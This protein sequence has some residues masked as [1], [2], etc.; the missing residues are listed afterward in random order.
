YMPKF[1][2]P[3]P[4]KGTEGG[5]YAT[6][7]L[8]LVKRDDD[9]EVQ[10][11]LKN[12]NLEVVYEAVNAIQATPYRLNEGLL[13]VLSQVA[14]ARGPKEVLPFIEIPPMPPRLPEKTTPEEEWKK[15]QTER[16]RVGKLRRLATRNFILIDTRLSIAESLRNRVFYFPH[17]VDNRSRAYPVPGEVHP[18]AD[19]MSRALLEFA[20]GKPLGERGVFWLSVHLANLWGH[21]I[22]KLPLA[23]RAQWVRDHEKEIVDSATR[24]LDGSMFWAGAEKKWRFLAASFEWAGYVQK[25][26]DFVSHLPIAMDGTC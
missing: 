12:A 9:L 19:D 5:G 4:W 1:G 17:Q 18:Q 21:K 10:Q 20:N 24:P 14:K 2:P 15:R 22:D 26:C 7:V 8:P 11:A 23:G 3:V 13:S 25:G 6:F 16:Y